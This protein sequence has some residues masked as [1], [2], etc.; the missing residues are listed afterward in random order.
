MGGGTGIFITEKRGT[1][2]RRKTYRVHRTQNSLY[3]ECRTQEG[4]DKY[5]P[6]IHQ[7]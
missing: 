5:Y 6:R 4:K 2:R 3:K 1:I 7:A